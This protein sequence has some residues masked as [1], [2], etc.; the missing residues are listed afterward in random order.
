MTKNMLGSNTV[1]EFSNWLC[2][3]LVQFQSARDGFYFSK[4]AITE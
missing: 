3:T 4:N 1:K 2:I